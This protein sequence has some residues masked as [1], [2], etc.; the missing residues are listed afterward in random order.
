M[1]RDVQKSASLSDLSDADLQK[2]LVYHYHYVRDL[3]QARKN[4]PYIEDLKTKIKEY[5]EEKYLEDLRS[6]KST[7]KA[8][9]ELCRLRGV[10]FE[11]P[12]TY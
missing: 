7:I 3:E 8:A 5:E 12:E 2:L 9:R 10:T 11:T 4:D 6:S 1:T